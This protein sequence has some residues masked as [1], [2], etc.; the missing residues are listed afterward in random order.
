[1]GFAW[2]ILAFVG[3]LWCMGMFW[4]YLTGLGKSFKAPP[5]ATIPSSHIKSKQRESVEDAQERHRKLM[6]DLKQKVS[7]TRR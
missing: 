2:L 6:D 5:A 7:D 1:M 4:G 3:G